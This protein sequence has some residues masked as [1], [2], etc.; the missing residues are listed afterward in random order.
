MKPNSNFSS[1]DDDSSSW[2]VSF[3]DI[4]LLLLCFFVLIFS[5]SEL[6]SS[7]SKEIYE[8]I[9]KS[10]MASEEVLE[11]IEQESLLQEIIYEEISQ[12]ILEKKLNNSLTLEKVDNGLKLKAAGDIL[13]KSASSELI[14]EAKLLLGEV[15][16]ILKSFN[17]NY[18][19]E[20]HTD[21]ISINTEKYPSNWEL[22]SS[23]ASSVARLFIQNNINPKQIS[24]QGY[25]DTKPEPY[26][27]HL[28]LS[29]NRAIN[30]RVVIFIKT[31]ENIVTNNK[32][33]KRKIKHPRSSTSKKSTKIETEN[34][35]GV[36]INLPL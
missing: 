31:E 6:K 33:Q 35:S 13:F 25:A 24:V 28:S 10:M 36:F 12:Y 26:Q 29:Q 2:L 30:R 9:S 21:D 23:R 3:S 22:S 11:K 7:K 27:D 8:S 32:R 18:S 14:S 4:S 17:Y 20:G 34:N 15:S 1:S 19:I 16:N 5:A